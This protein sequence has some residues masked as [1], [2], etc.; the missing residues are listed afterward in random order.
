[1]R[2]NATGV[3]HVVI[4]C[5]VVVVVMG[6]CFWLRLVR[7]AMQ[8]LLLFLRVWDKSMLRLSALVALET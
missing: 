6:R 2:C 4:V 8:L 3:A 7:A 1:M 5:V